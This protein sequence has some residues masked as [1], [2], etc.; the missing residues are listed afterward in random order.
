MKTT[1][2]F[3]LML[4]CAVLVA[5]LFGG[6]RLNEHAQAK[7]DQWLEQTKRWASDPVLVQAVAAQNQTLAPEL[8]AMTQ[9]K[10]QGLSDLDPLVFALTRNSVG[11]FLK[12]KKTHA[13]TEAFV[14]DARGLK[15]G[16]LKK[17]TSWCHQG[18]PKHDEPMA[19]KVWQGKPEVDQSSGMTQVQIALPILAEGKPIGSLV[20]GVSIAA[21]LEE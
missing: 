18:K 20:L 19:G 4:I 6:D 16:F 1:L 8:A 2:R 17:T 10:W 11:Q 5:P 9:E 12:T 14:S 15:V 21:L 13:L 7:L 3:S